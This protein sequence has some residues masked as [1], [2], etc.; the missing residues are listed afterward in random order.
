MA[1]GVWTPGEFTM[2][3]NAVACGMATSGGK[4]LRF[5][6]HERQIKDTDRYGDTRIDGIYRGIDAYLV[7]TFKEWNAAVRSL[8]WP[9]SVPATPVFDG[10]LGL[11]GQVAFDVA[12]A[13]VLTPVALTPAAV[14][15]GQTFTASKAKLAPENDI[16]ILMG[17]DERDVPV[18]FDLLPYDDAG[19][20]RMWT[21]S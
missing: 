5:R 12:K 1:L 8:I 7:V 13:I 17:P 14:L 21:F 11:I 6:T 4:N 3:Y 15:T 10:K 2:T 20:I 19:V 16:N 18:I 9:W